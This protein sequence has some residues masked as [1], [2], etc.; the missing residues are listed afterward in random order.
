MNNLVKINDTDLVVKEFNGQRIVTLKEID[1]V[2]NRPDGTARRNFNENRKHFNEGE[3]Y[4]IRNSYEAKKEFNI[5][6]PNGLTI[7][8]ESGYLMLVKSFQDEL[9]WKVQ[10]MLVNSYFRGNQLNNLSKELQAIFQL[11]HKQQKFETRLDKLENN[12]TIDFG[13]QRNLQVLAQKT[14][15]QIIGGKETPAYKNKPI[16]SKVFS[17]LWKDYKDYMQVASYRDTLKIDYN[18]A[19]TYITKWRLNGKLLREV[20]ECNS[21]MELV[22]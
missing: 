7:I 21:Q 13:Q 11:D 4:F 5:I 17:S 1:Q 10:R 2:H 12:T 19:V 8:T 15:L 18:R 6:A 20:E 3:D 14:V 22:I 9:S 16:R